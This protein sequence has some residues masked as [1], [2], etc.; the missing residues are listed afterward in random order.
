[1]QLEHATNSLG[2]CPVDAV[3]AALPPSEDP[4][5]DSFAIRQQRYDA[6][7]ATRSIVFTWTDLL[8]GG[9]PVILTPE[10]ADQALAEAVR[11]CGAKIAAH[12]PGGTIVKLMLAELSPG[13]AI[14]RHRD[15]G[16]LLEGV[17]RCHVAV[18]TNAHVE[19]LIDDVARAFPVGE[20][21]EVD[22]TRPHA[23]TNRGTTR[24]VHLICDVMPAQTG[25]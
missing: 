11:A 10:F 6:H 23:V 12:F 19:F 21:I 17:H 7:N 8:L 16:V 5:W 22:N 20:A 3:R 25:E 24:R 9:K 15:S 13:G 2:P 18:E 14:K 1:M 4:V